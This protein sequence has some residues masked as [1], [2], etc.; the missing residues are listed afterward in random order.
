MINQ[1]ESIFKNFKMKL[2]NTP[3]HFPLFPR[4]GAEGP[5]GK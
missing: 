1:Y 2:P 5:L 3:F 4:E